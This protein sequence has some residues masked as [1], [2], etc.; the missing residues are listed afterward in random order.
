[1]MMMEGKKQEERQRQQLQ[2]QQQQDVY[3]PKIEKV[4]LTPF[5]TNAKLSLRA[6]CGNLDVR[7]DKVLKMKLKAN[8]K[9]V[10]FYNWEENQNSVVKSNRAIYVEFVRVKYRKEGGGG[11]LLG[12][13]K[14]S[15]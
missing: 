15:S 9:N 5:T 14:T 7:Q 10:T 1:M 2:L 11:N 4:T 13:W 8:D 6:A 3:H 12:N